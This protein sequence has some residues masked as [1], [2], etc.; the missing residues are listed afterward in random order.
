MK[1]HVCNVDKLSKEFPRENITDDCDHPPIHCLRVIIQ[2]AMLD[3]RPTTL[4]FHLAY[5]YDVLVKWAY[6]N[7]W[8]LV[9]ARIRQTISLKNG[10]LLVKLLCY[11]LSATA[12]G[13]PVGISRRSC[14][15]TKLEWMGY[16]VVTKAWQYVQPFWYNTSVLRIDRQ[17][18]GLT[19]L[20]YQY[21]ASV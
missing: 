18:D 14:I 7:L 8:T 12:G 2:F 13:D 21:R 17:T 4:L 11:S 10:A 19:E 1:C 6:I 3:W 20:L 9:E 16:R 5:N 15:H